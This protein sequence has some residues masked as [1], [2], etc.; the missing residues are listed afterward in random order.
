MI[1][2]YRTDKTS[3]KSPFNSNG[4]IKTPSSSNS[5]NQKK[6]SKNPIKGKNLAN[7]M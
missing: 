1:N 3:L 6:E 7:Y 5:K 4:A 2:M